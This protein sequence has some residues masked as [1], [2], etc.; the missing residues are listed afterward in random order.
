MSMISWNME[1]KEELRN[2]GLALVCRKQQKWN[3][4]EI[5]KIVIDVMI[6]KHEYFSKILREN[7]LTLYQEIIFPWGKN[8]L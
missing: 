1:L 6:L 3:L 5:T 4:R 2:I 8:H 7:S